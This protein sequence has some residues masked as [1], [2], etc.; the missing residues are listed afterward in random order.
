MGKITIRKKIGKSE[1][2]FVGDSKKFRES[3]KEAALYATTPDKCTLCKSEDVTLDSNTS[4]EGYIFIKVKC[5]NEK[6]GA[7][8]TLGVHKDEQSGWWKE[9][10]IY[11]PKRG[12]PA[13]EPKKEK[14]ASESKSTKKDDDNDD[15]DIFS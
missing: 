9:F 7:A 2:G 4:Q 15:D 14:T 10:E 5:L 12:G 6:C 11:D 13:S 1:L 3:L 8:A